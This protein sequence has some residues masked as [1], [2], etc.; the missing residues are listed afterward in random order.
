MLLYIDPGAGSFIIQAI[1]A[2]F[3]GFLFYFNLIKAK[4]INLFKKKDDKSSK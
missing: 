4:I 1:I 3:L 2:G